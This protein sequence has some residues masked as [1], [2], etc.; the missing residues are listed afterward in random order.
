[1]SPFG[2]E[3]AALAVSYPVFGFSYRGRPI[4]TCSESLF[5][6]RSRGRVVAVGSSV[7]VL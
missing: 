2:K 7:Y 6:Q 4:E 3:L 1:M 5:D